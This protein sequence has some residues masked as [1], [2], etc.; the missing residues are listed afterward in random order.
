MKAVKKLDSDVI[1]A[2]RQIVSDMADCQYLT[3]KEVRTDFAMTLA[4]AF[5]ATDSG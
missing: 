4:K 1:R 2:S 3:C 5:S